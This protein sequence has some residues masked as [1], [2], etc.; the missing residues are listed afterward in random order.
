MIRRKN[1]LPRHWKT[2]DV[3]KRKLV[4]AEPGWPCLCLE[5][6]AAAFPNGEETRDADNDSTCMYYSNNQLHQLTFDA[7]LN[8]IKNIHVRNWVKSI[9]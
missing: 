9:I 3:S 4:Y 8:K 6:E 2:A 7:S 1:K 5:T